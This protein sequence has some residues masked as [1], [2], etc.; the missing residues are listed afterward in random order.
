VKRQ[1]GGLSD[2]ELVMLAKKGDASAFEAIYDRHSPGV[3]RALASFAGPD[4]DL[5]DDL[6]QDVFLRVIQGLETYV[7]THPFSHW[8]YTIV[9]NTGRNHARRP[10]RVI[11]VDPA[12][13]EGLSSAVGKP[14]EWP[15]Q[16]ASRNLMR[17]V[18]RLP[19]TMQDVIAL[20]IG[21]DLPYGEIAVLLGI[22]EGTARSRMSNAMAKLREQLRTGDSR[23]SSEV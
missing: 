7:P 5:L 8:L 15:E 6:T 11:P 14:P 18:S 22:S 12:D 19:H 2:T 10:A 16:L 9:L 23:R 20:R 21:S 1:L 13:L 3:A 4:Q 17:L